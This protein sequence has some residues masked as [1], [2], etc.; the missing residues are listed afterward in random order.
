[1]KKVICFLLM[2]SL[3]L[4]LC[5]CQ[6]DAKPA[7]AKR[8]GE[9]AFTLHIIGP[10]PEF[11]ALDVVTA[12]YRQLY[13]GAVVEYEYMQNSTEMLPK[14]LEA[15]EDVDIFISDNIEYETS[16]YYPYALDLY[17]R[18]D[19]L[20]LDNT[21]SGLIANYEFKGGAEGEAR[22]YSIPMG[23]EVRGLYVNKTLLES[24]G[25]AQLPQNRAELLAD[26]QVLKDA[27]Y[28][29]LHGNPGVFAQQLMYPEIAN[30]IANAGDGGAL[31]K[32]INEH[33][34]DVADLFADEMA[35]V[36]SLAENGYYDY[37]TAASELGL[38]DS[39]DDEEK[40]C[41]FLNILSDGEGR[42]KKDD[43]G[44]AAFVPGVMSLTPLLEK[45][46]ADY[47]SAIE[48][49]FMLAPVG[50]EDGGYA[51]LSPA[52]AIA[53]NK[54]SPRLEEALA[55]FNC[56]F[57]AEVSPAFAAEYGIVPNVKDA[58]EQIKALFSIPENHISQLGQVTFD[59]SFYNVI[60]AELVIVSK[61]NNPKYMI[62]NGDGTYSMHPL[63]E[64]M[65]ELR[66]RFAEVQ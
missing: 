66:A 2:L 48:Y 46:K 51:Y 26:C 7:S 12:A 44:Q 20:N 41:S 42:T 53:I 49:E 19:A 27:G 35:F 65:Q 54:N 1:M 59:Y 11:K 56:M 18:A 22:L 6:S 5:G 13:P 25:I 10:W 43:V 3:L 47:H 16:A 36:Y 23:G 45:T 55:Y 40:A 4:T 52:H 9:K 8:S 15:N 30:R 24:V 62:D 29:A 33:G 21:F 50:A 60:V 57:S 28:I 38:F 63:D 34:A 32:Q 61:A 64:Y 31:W 14:R 39:M 58:F 37:K 17:S